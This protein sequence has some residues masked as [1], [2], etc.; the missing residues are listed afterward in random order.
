MNL[1]FF[2]KY[3][4]TSKR[5]LSKFKSR[6]FL[7]SIF[8]IL[9]KFFMRLVFIG[10][11]YSESIPIDIYVKS[12]L[13]GLRF[14]IATTFVMLAPYMLFL[15]YI[16]N[17]Y[18][19]KIQKLYFIIITTFILLIPMIDLQYYILMGNR[20]D[21]YGFKHI[22]FILNHIGMLNQGFTTVILLILLLFLILVNNFIINF[23]LKNSPERRYRVSNY[24]LSLV[25]SIVCIRGGIQPYPITQ[26]LSNFSEYKLANDTST[27]SIYR[28]YYI[29]KYLI[30]ESH[31]SD[32]MIY[33]YVQKNMDIKKAAKTLSKLYSDSLYTSSLIREHKSKNYLNINSQNKKKN[34]I[35]IIVESFASDYIHSLG[36]TNED[37]PYFDSLIHHGI[38]FDN[39]YSNGTHTNEALGAILAG[40][41]HL[42]RGDILSM[43]EFIDGVQTLPSILKE[44]KYTTQ[45]IYGGRLSFDNMN[46]FLS[47]S[48]V[49]NF[50]GRS[51]FPSKLD[52]TYWGI[53][54]EHVYDK[55]IESLSKIRRPF[56]TTILTLS[57]HHPWDIPLDSISPLPS[58][59]EQSKRR[60]TFR[61]S[62]WAL[63]DFLKKVKKSDY[64]DD[65]IIIITSDTGQMLY[66]DYDVEPRNYRI[67]LLILNSGLESRIN[68][69]LG[70]Q[71]DLL[72]T[73]LDILNISVDISSFG[74][75]LFRENIKNRFVPLFQN[76]S[77]ILLFDDTIYI[78]NPIKPYGLLL[79]H[80]NY[81]ISSINKSYKNDYYKS[82]T[83]SLLFS[84]DYSI[85]NYKF[86]YR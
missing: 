28:L 6:V 41:P 44:H 52:N 22:K 77:S 21:L 7:F 53:A 3:L 5:F 75:S 34:I 11:N 82:L 36:A 79:Y 50:I 20:F 4:M 42:P 73:V 62:D 72:P 86:L 57:N 35:L 40:Y 63:N 64:Y 26:N 84:T 38:L 58:K 14:D 70:S 78:D 29:I 66:N 68:H 55:A 25:I 23:I 43:P 8:L 49:D 56:I 27:N 47:A 1:R 46:S 32:N 76:N 69:T 2:I 45:F 16:N 37:T 30:T 83:Q 17:V 10:F 71:I 54:D 31:S 65:T 15:S 33:N 51:D 12:F 85:K 61:Y 59:I 48:G 74:R 24:I 80:S 60:N 19:K 39:F 67:P 9:T 13:L 18:S 81:Q